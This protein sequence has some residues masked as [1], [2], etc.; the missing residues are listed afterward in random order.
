[1]RCRLDRWA[2][3]VAS[4]A[5][6]LLQDACIFDPRPIDPARVVANY[7]RAGRVRGIITPPP[8]VRVS[9]QIQHRGPTPP[10]RFARVCWRRRSSPCCGLVAPAPSAPWLELCQR[11]L[12][13][14]P[15][16]R[17]V[18]H[19]AG[20]V[21]EQAPEIDVAAFAN[22]AQPPAGA[23]GI[24]ARGQAQPARKLSRP[25]KPVN[26]P[27]GP[28]QRRR[29]EQPNAR[30]RAQ[31]RGVSGVSASSRIPGIARRAG[32][33]P[34]GRSRPCSRKIPRSALMRAVRVVIH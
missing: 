1:M 11:L 13:H 34:A 31:P 29:G 32:P 21:G 28:D 26:V 4:L 33:A 16:M 5:Q 14:P 19:G 22:A 30:N 27:H 8:E 2:I 10:R 24:F 7:P 9:D 20:T 3:V 12:S 18:E 17:G 25:A 6:H 15:P 23:A